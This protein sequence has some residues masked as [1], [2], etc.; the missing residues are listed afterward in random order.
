MSR[1]K[2]YGRG[3]VKIGYD[4]KCT[5]CEEIKSGVECVSI[6]PVRGMTGRILY[7]GGLL[8]CPSC[9]KEANAFWKQQHYGVPPSCEE[10]AVTFYN[11]KVV[12]S[13]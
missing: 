4:W 3:N 6:G 7:W 9:R 8:I 1:A 5:G 12:L 2:G 10:E 13:K 11:K